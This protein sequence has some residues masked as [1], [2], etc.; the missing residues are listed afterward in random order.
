MI[1]K[2]N[3]GK[4]TGVIVRPHQ[5]VCIQYFIKKAFK[6]YSCKKTIEIITLPF[7]QRYFFAFCHSQNNVKIHK[8]NIPVYKKLKN[9]H[10]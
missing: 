1:P 5:Y 9:N 7:L 3:K 8:I 4:N 10:S 6:K 2:D